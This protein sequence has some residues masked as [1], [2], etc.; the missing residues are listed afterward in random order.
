MTI[1]IKGVI[2]LMIS[3]KA[4]KSSTQKELYLRIHRA[5]DY[6]SSC[7]SENLTIQSLAE[8]ACLNQHYFL[9]E[10]KKIITTTPHQYLQKVRLA[11]AGRLLINTENS[12]GEVC[13]AVGFNDI[14]SFCKL[15]KRNFLLTPSDFRKKSYKLSS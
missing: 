15:F 13:N 8:V 2:E 10:F 9:R 7:Y 5:K 14:A 1:G 6:I 12:V 3:V 11:E 4:L